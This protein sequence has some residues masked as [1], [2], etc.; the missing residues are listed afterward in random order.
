MNGWFNGH[1]MLTV[2]IKPTDRPLAER[3]NQYH[4][5]EERQQLAEPTPMRDAT[6][7]TA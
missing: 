5:G 4:N 1:A 3:D 7:T 6:T 2:Q